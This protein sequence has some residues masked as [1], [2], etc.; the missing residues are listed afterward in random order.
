[1]AA[2]TRTELRGQY[3]ALLA[4]YTDDIVSMC[5]QARSGMATASLALLEIDL[6][7]AETAISNSDAVVDTQRQC[8]ARALELLALQAPVAS[9][10]RRVM[11]Y[12]R[13]EDHL[14]RMANL[15]KLVA[16]ISR[17]HYPDYAVPEDV[18]TEIAA[19]AEAVD[20][21]AALTAEFLREPDADAARELDAADE[22]VDEAASK[23]AAL[24]KDKAW[25]HTACEAVETALIARY[26]E[27]FADHCVAIGQQVV[28]ITGER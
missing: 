25:A 1:M 2:D 10:L 19:M 14:V 21:M 28:F 15:A 11:A 22:P 16:K 17:Q 6:E 4:G 13:I 5:E 18:R 7:A 24:A 26:Y 9:E 23:L 20:E 27:R 12:I 8:E 3:R